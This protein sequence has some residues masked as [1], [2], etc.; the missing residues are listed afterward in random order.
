MPLNQKL[1]VDLYLGNEMSYRD[2]AK[3]CGCC[4]SKVQYW[5]N[6]YGI[7]PR[8]R[9]KKTSNGNLDKRMFQQKDGRIQVVLEKSLKANAVLKATAVIE[10]DWHCNLCVH[11]ING[12]KSDDR[13]ENL[14]IANHYIHQVSS[15]PNSKCTHLEEAMIPL[16]DYAYLD[17]CLV[18]TDYGY[19][20]HANFEPIPQW[21][22][23]KIAAAH[24]LICSQCGLCQ[25]QEQN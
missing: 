10:G 9:A 4:H 8:P 15:F 17:D 25:K 21:K 7:P 18:L 5:I 16:T 12:D 6:E 13:Y 3:Y 22:I 1:L 14:A 19:R 2:I 23:A 20:V 24:F 11:H